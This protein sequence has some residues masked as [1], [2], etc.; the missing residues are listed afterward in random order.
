M[1]R[2]VLSFV[3]LRSES[4]LKLTYS[5][6]MVGCTAPVYG[7]DTFIGAL[8]VALSMAQTSYLVKDLTS[9]PGGYSEKVI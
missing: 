9:T 2:A 6:M 3:W 5:E 1:E 8:A 4:S 7:N